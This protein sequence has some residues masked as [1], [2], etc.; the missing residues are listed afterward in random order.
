MLFVFN[1]L[2][3]N[4]YFFSV[5]ALALASKFNEIKQK[6]PFTFALMIFLLVRR[7]CSYPKV[8]AALDVEMIVMS[9]KARKKK[10]NEDENL[11]LS[12]I[13]TTMFCFLDRRC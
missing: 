4:K 3:L 2:I 7:L 13:L 6:I 8:A 1:D 9:E 12:I 11:S 5:A 10:R